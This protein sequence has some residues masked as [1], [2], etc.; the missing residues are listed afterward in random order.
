MNNS[1]IILAGG[2]GSRMKGVVADKCLANLCGKPVILHS[3]QA[4]IL[5]E[6]VSEIVFVC[7]DLEQENSIKSAVCEPAKKHGVK[8][9]FTRGGKERY[10]SVLNGINAS[11]ENSEFVFIH[12]GAR[13]LV[14]SQNIKNLFLSA[15]KFGASVLAAKVVN[16]IKKNESFPETEFCKLADLDRK[17]LFAMQT[18]QVFKRDKILEAYNYVISNNIQITDDVAA[19]ST[20]GLNVAVVENSSYNPKIT[21][22][23]DIALVEYIISKKNESKI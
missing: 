17:T 3:A 6:C 4:F 10:N 19:Y 20:L 23:D 14:G 7:R 13:P 22:P 16:T 18:P 11:S 1:A 2:S 15:Q 5:S 12:D 9:V 8:T 21:V